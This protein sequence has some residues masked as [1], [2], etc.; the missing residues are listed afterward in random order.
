MNVFGFILFIAGF[1]GIVIFLVKKCHFSI[2]ISPLIAILSATFLL[3]LFAICGFLKI[4]LYI[5]LAVCALLGILAFIKIKGWKEDPLPLFPLAVLGVILIGIF[6]YTRGALFWVWDEFSH[7]GVIFRYLMTTD[8]LPFQTA[9]GFNIVITNYPPFSALFEYMV[10]K[11]IGFNE[12][13]AYFAFMLM[14]YAAIYSLLP[15]KS[16]KS[17]SKYLIS[18]LAMLISVIAF[19]FVFQSL[20]VDLIIGLL[21]AAGIIYIYYSPTDT[22]RDILPVLLICMALTLLKPTGFFFALVMIGLNLILA[23]YRKHKLHQQKIP[24]AIFRSIF[25][26]QSLCLLLISML[27]FMSWNYYSKGFPGDKIIFTLKDTNVEPNDINPIFP[28]QYLNELKNDDLVWWKKIMLGEQNIKRVSIQEILRSFTANAPYRTQL[29]ATNFFSKISD[30][31]SMTYISILDGFLVIL[32]ISIINHFLIRKT[33]NINNCPIT[34]LNI[35]LAVGSIFYMIIL[36]FSYIFYFTI[37]EAIHVPSLGRYIGSY[38]LAWWLINLSVMGKTSFE[39]KAVGKIDFSKY[40]SVAIIV[41]A[42]LVVPMDKI[43]HLPPVPDQ[44]RFLMARMV[45][46]IKTVELTENDKIFIIEQSTYGDSGL[47]FYMTRYLLTPLQTNV[48]GYQL[49]VESNNMEKNMIE[50]SPVDWLNFL[51]EK[52]YT[53]VFVLSSTEQFWD[54]YEKIFTNFEDMNIPQLFKVTPTGLVKIPLEFGNMKP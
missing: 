39:I 47:A 17:W 29:I 8:Q 30:P 11:V 43:I 31:K 21:F 13:N 50:I 5:I 37:I 16:W 44:N 1:L 2:A 36:Y 15:V 6:F 53:Y 54:S 51:I 40:F 25:S 14:E 10:A 52:K 7:W 22:F 9:R 41:W 4:G 46:T 33:T 20:Y 27:V 35:I 23:I 18:F 12:S 45:K 19:G 49:S 32:A 3:Y 38:L 42:L 26:I 48:F 34:N 28:S 24:R